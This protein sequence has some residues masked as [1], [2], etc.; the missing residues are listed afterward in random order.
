MAWRHTELTRTVEGATFRHGRNSRIKVL[1]VMG[2]P[3]RDRLADLPALVGHCLTRP[4][5]GEGKPP[6]M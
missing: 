4:Y 3:R 5:P 1:K 2:P 6:R